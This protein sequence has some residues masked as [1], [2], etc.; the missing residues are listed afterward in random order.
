MTHY[1]AYSDESLLRPVRRPIRRRT[2]AAAWFLRAVL[3][4][5]LLAGGV[6]LVN[7][8]INLSGNLDSRDGRSTDTTPIALFIGRQRLVIPANM[9][10]FADQRNVGP[11]DRIDLAVHFPEMAGYTRDFRKDF[12]DLSADAPIVYLTIRTRDTPTDSVGRL[13]NVYQHFFEEG[14]IPAPDG[15]VGHRMSEDSGLSGE[16]VFFEAGSTT[17]FTTHCTAPD[18]TE[19]PASCLTEIH[20]GNDLSVQIR[21]RKG[22]LGDWAGIKSGVRVLLLSFGV[23]V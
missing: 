21:F 12:L 16:E 13:I 4:T 19:Y 3:T 17:P 15:L 10:R 6:M 8:L 2:S 7:I 1:A 20:A 14:T 22:L 23:T 5:F 18:D 9:L 11:H